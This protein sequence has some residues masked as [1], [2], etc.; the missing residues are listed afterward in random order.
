MT[1]ETIGFYF[2]CI[3]IYVGTPMTKEKATLEQRVASF[4]REIEFQKKERELL[5]DWRIGHVHV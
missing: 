5:H 1:K 2:R 3:H 4:K